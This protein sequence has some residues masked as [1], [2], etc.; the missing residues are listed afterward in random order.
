MQKN[1]KSVLMCSF[2]YK[3]V[4][5]MKSFYSTVFVF[6]DIAEMYEFHLCWK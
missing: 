3:E 5:N 4:H 2:V 1:C 6:K